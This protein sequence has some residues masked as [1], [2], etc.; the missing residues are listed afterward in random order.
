VSAQARA[1]LRGTAPMPGASVTSVPV[2]SKAAATLAMG[3][4]AAA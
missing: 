1:T 2:T 3:T 4:P